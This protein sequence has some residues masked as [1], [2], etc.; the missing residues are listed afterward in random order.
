[1]SL[2]AELLK[3]NKSGSVKKAVVV[4]LVKTNREDIRSIDFANEVKEQKAGFAQMLGVNVE[5]I[6][7]D[8]LSLDDAEVK[9]NLKNALKGYKVNEI[10]VIHDNFNNEKASWVLDNSLE[11]FVEKANQNYYS[12]FN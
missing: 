7:K 8:I 11:Y 2:Y 1:M 4:L 10:E 12:L 6:V 9:R 3:G 5:I